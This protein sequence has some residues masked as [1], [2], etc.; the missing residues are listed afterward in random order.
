MEEIITYLGAG[1]AG[2]ISWIFASNI[3]LREGISDALLK[4]LNKTKI[5]YI[6]LNNH[7]VFGALQQKRSIF[8]YFIMDEPIKIAFYT[9]FINIVFDELDTAVND[10]IKLS[11]KSEDITSAI[12]NCISKANQNI[13]T[14]VDMQLIIPKE[15]DK[16]FYQWRQMISTGLKDSL[17]EILNDDLMNSNY[18]LVYRTLDCLIAYIKMLLLSGALE[19]SKFNGAFKTLTMDDILKQPENDNKPVSK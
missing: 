12:F 13:D 10:I 14:Q 19:F 11:N 5:N 1:I 18:L 3:K 9:K 15:I 6:P 16:A 7:R 2:A 17:I 8:T 4:R